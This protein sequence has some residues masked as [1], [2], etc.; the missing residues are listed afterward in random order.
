[1]IRYP[2]AAVSEPTFA[3][4]IGIQSVWFN[5]YCAQQKEKGLP[6]PTTLS[7]VPKADVKTA[8]VQ[9]AELAQARFQNLPISICRTSYTNKKGEVVDRL[10]AF[11]KAGNLLGL[12]TP[13]SEAY[14]ADEKP[15]TLR[16]ALACDGNVR[17]V[18]K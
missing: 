3:R 7:D 18:L 11:T 9:V 1:V 13:E 12:I 14:I 5:W 6:V 15:L 10:G 17:A 2:D 8:K 4:S 16:F